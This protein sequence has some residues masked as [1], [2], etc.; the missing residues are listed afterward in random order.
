MKKLR[1][2]RWRWGGVLLWGVCSSLV[3]TQHPR[4]LLLPTA[5]AQSPDPSTA[6]TTPD[7][8]SQASDR[9]SLDWLE[10][11]NSALRQLPPLP[12]LQYRQQVR[13]EGSQTFTAT[14]DV[15]YRRDGS[16]QAWVAE[17]DR[18]RLLD[19]RQLEVVNQSDLLGLYSVY[20]NR[21]EALL[22]SVGFNLEAPPTAYRVL[23]SE[24]VDLAGSPAQHLRLEPIQEG[25]LRELWLDPE[26]G[27]PRQALLF[28]SGV[29][30]QAYALIGFT[31]VPTEGGVSYWLPESTRIN[32]GYGFWTL[33]GLTRRVFRGSL[34]IQHDYQEHRILPE[35]TQLRFVPSQ[36]PVDDL[37][38]VAGLSDS[39]PPI[40]LG[41]VQALGVDEQGNQQF[42]IGIGG[43][44]SPETPLEDRIAA[45]NLTRPASR[46]VL[47]QIDTLAFLPLGSDRLPIYLFQFD[48]G[49]PLSPLQGIDSPRVDPNEVF[50]PRPPAL[51]LFGD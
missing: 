51:K 44:S 5:F 23:S 13:V 15:L 12:N 33:E 31:A 6:A 45:F 7:Q 32:L 43:R 49:R 4:D 25:Q 46:N 48:T 40:E 16:W 42:S 36:P 39:T 35:G 11:Y 8:A 34:S 18:I 47:T 41:D 21:P 3:A 2:Q 26:S 28:L 20:V 29:W 9:A 27:L 38:V 17:G 19:S 24:R 22:P 30:G 50:S 14:L 1:R 10:R 37:P